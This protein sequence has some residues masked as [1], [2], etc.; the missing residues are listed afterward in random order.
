MILQ[1][2]GGHRS[3]MQVG[4]QMIDPP[5]EGNRCVMSLPAPGGRQNQTEGRVWTSWECLRLIDGEA[6]TEVSKI[7]RTR[8]QIFYFQDKGTWS[9]H[10]ADQ[11]KGLSLPDNS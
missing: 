9:F 4:G 10:S 11:P 5:R 2:L 1:Y 3:A 8:R 7:A 6:A